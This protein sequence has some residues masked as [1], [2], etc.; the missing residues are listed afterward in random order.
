MIEFG[1]HLFREKPIH[2]YGIG[3][4]ASMYH[5]AT[6]SH[7]N[8]I[9]LMVSGGAIALVMYYLMLLI[10]SAGLL[11]SRKKG[12]SLN[13][14]HLMLWIWVEV[15]FSVAMVQL[16]NKNSW[17]LMGVLIAESTHAIHRKNTLQENRYEGNA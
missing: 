1:L 5:I 17:L 8:Y 9:E 12:D 16:Y 10:P 13:N 2:G 3:N 11:L 14:L 6:Y 15:V 7:N 4:Y